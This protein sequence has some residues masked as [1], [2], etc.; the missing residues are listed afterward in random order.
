[1]YMCV[2]VCVYI[3][4]LHTIQDMPVIYVC[5]YI[6]IYGGESCP[7]HKCVMHR[8]ND[9]RRTG[10]TC[11]CVCAYIYIQVIYTYNCVCVY[12]NMCF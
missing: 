6:R 1:M 8:T 9:S 5:I 3:Y 2:C 11:V 10:C 12:M 4:Q 7:L